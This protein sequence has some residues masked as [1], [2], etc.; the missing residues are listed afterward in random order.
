MGKS[1]A[2]TTDKTAQGFQLHTPEATVVDEGTEFGVEVT[3]GGSRVHVFQ[4][5][6]N[7]SLNN[8][9][10]L[11]NPV[12]RLTANSEA[13]L[14]RNPSNLTLL[15]D[16]GESF[17]RS[18]G[19][20]QRDRH[21]VAYWRFEDRPLG[22]VLPDTGQNTNPVR[23]TMDSSYNGNDLFTFTPRHGPRF[24][25]DVPANVVPQTGASNQG[26]L[27]NT[28]RPEGALSRD[29]YTRSGFS[30]AAPMD[31]QEITPV[32]WTIEASV[33]VK[34]QYQ[35]P[36]TFVT[37]D[38]KL[39]E[40]PWLSFQIDNLD[41]FA[42]RFVDVEQRPHEAVAS[43]LTLKTNHW[44]HLAATSDGQTLKLYVDC[45]DGHG[46]QLQASTELPK[47][48][49]TALGKTSDPNCREWALG[50]I[51][52]QNRDVYS[53]FQ[54]WIDEVRISNVALSPENFLFAPKPKDKDTH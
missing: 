26:C 12:Q 50:R 46:Y 44:Y 21:T 17:I 32:A 34:W 33:K 10:G 18:M 42:I 29:L 27:D 2:L 43:K 38:G 16:T 28:E 30:H 45:L 11:A 14:E 9:A 51:R 23:A 6:V 39:G 49:S 40:Q 31:L 24:S 36:Q 52:V 37:R 47:S 22:V 8:K 53:W 15:K 5:S 4:G 1:T 35:G 25:G 3:K 20:S 7:L 13:R 54:G 48:G 19:Q 41:R